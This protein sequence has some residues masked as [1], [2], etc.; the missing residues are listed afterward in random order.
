[1]TWLYRSK[2]VTGGAPGRTDGPTLTLHQ[3]I[4]ELRDS[5][6]RTALPCCWI[7]AR[8]LGVMVISNLAICQTPP[9]AKNYWLLFYIRNACYTIYFGIMFSIQWLAISAIGVIGNVCLGEDEF[10]QQDFDSMYVIGLDSCGTGIGCPA[11]PSRAD[12]VTTGRIHF[13]ADS[14]TR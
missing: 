6:S 10:S 2:S 7:K 3:P 8:A 5:A 11:C 12:A 4:M 14:P 9:A 1:M 13:R